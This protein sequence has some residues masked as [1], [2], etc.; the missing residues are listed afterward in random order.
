LGGLVVNKENL[1][2]AAAVGGRKQS[3]LTC[4]YGIIQRRIDK[5][6]GSLVKLRVYYNSLKEVV[7]ENRLME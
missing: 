1:N 3:K 7:M 6:E 5:S 4:A 2:E